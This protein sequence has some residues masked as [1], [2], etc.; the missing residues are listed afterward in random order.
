[1]K[2]VL[3]IAALLAAALSCCGT[4]S[5]SGLLVAN[6]DLDGAAA[7]VQAVVA[8]ATAADSTTFVIAAQPDAPRPLILTIT[9]ADSSITA[10]TITVTGLDSEGDVITLVHTYAGG[11]STTVTSTT[12]FASVTSVISSVLTGEGGVADTMSVGTTAT[13]PMIYCAYQ[14][15]NH[16]PMGRA[17]DGAGDVAGAATAI[18]SYTTGDGSLAG[19]SLY[20]LLLFN[21]DGVQTQ[22]VIT[23][24]T[25]V[26]AVVV[27]SSTTVT[28][29][30]YRYMR[31]HCGTEATD[32]W[33]SVAQ[34]GGG[35]F[36]FTIDVEQMVV[37]GGVDVTIY[38]RDAS[39][40]MTP[41]PLW[42]KNYAAAGIDT[43]TVETPFSSCRVGVQV[44][45]NDDANDLTT[46]KEIINLYLQGLD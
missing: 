44:G 34:F 4:A 46:N 30:G 9:D 21:V 16:I 25:S 14:G 41:V 7:N 43:F 40:F 18:T 1:V 13:I 31:H 3:K 5:A 24:W 11:G 45:T 19:T 37:T 29:A 12:N 23:T 22:R 35:P 6:Y 32:S 20:D 26:D 28:R 36:K 17:I 10:G 42:T 2:A 27:D 33:F 39:T 15:L 38:C 8:T